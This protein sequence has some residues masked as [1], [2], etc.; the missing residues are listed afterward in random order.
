MKSTALF[1]LAK[2][3]KGFSLVE[4]LIAMVI[5]AIALMALAGVVVSTTMLMAHTI[6]KENAVNLGVEMLETLEAMNFEGENIEDF[7]YTPD[8]DSD[9][10]KFSPTWE[11]EN[12]TGGKNITMVVQW[13]GILGSREVTLER[14]VADPGPD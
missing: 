13:N 12:L 10:S 6:D 11:V 2:Q 3:R 1:R 5:L 7:S 4:V 14:F 9:D 8:D